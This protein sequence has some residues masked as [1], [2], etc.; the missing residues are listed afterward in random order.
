MPSK[1][2]KSNQEYSGKPKS[3]TKMEQSGLKGGGKKGRNGKQEMEGN[4]E[5]EK[6]G[7]V[8]DKSVV[9]AD[10]AQTNIDTDDAETNSDERFVKIDTHVV[11]T[12]VTHD[13][14]TIDERVVNTIDTHVVNI[15]ERVAQIHIDT[16]VAPTNIHTHVVNG[17][18]THDVNIDRNVVNVDTH[19]VKTM[20][21]VD[22][23]I[24]IDGAV[25]NSD[26]DDAETNIDTDDIYIDLVVFIVDTHVVNMIHSQTSIDTH[27]VMFDGDFFSIAVITY[28]FTRTL[29][30]LHP[31]AV[32]H[33]TLHD[34]LDS[35]ND[36]RFDPP[37]LVID[38]LTT[39]LFS[40]FVS[41]WKRLFPFVS[42]SLCTHNSTCP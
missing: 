3:T 21:T 6:G 31:T 33:Q 25:V 14:N 24:K 35:D 11:N 30:G 20:D 37:F 38:S 34:L 32:T 18:D 28:I 10:D 26:M 22:A 8:E 7:T 4:R 1:T 23:Q 39:F 15:D 9:N 42:L 29:L 13:V 5:G 17:S 40:P 16:D 27:I 36:C 41:L 19:D 12:I 2:K